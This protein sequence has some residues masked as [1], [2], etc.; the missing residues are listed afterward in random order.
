MYILSFCMFRKSLLLEVSI[1]SILIRHVRS[2]EHLK[3]LFTGSQKEALFVFKKKKTPFPDI[4]PLLQAIS[5]LTPNK[6]VKGKTSLE[7]FLDLSP[8]SFPQSPDTCCPQAAS[9][10]SPPTPGAL[11][12]FLNSG[13]SP[14][15]KN[16]LPH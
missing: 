10:C 11:P 5:G 13:L 8:R 12:G 14:P 2:Y 9:S 4:F 16:L 7:V 6:S 3:K 1:V 15:S